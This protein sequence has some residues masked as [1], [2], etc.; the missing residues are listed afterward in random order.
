[1]LLEIFVYFDWFRYLFVYLL[2]NIKNFE[3]VTK[4][5][6]IYFFISNT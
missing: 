1:M 5:F 6:R 3:I 2:L 4:L